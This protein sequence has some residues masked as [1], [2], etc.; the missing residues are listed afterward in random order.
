MLDNDDDDGGD[1]CLGTE[2]ASWLAAG[3]GGTAIT[4]KHTQS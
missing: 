1:D 4:R 2:R 3:Q